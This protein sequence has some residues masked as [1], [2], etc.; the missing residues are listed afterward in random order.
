VSVTR[1]RDQS[2]FTLVELLVV[3]AIIGILVALLLPAIQAARE[4]ARS[5][6]CTNRMR[7]IAIGMQLYHDAN[8]AFPTGGSKKSNDGKGNKYNIG[9]AYL[10]MPYIEETNRRDQ[11]NL[12]HPNAFYMIEPWRLTNPPIGFGAQPVFTDPIATF[13]CPSSELGLLSPNAEPIADPQCNAENQGALHYR[14]NGGSATLEL[15]EGTFSRHA[16]YCTSGVIYPDSK[17][18]MKKITDGTSHTILLGETSSSIGRE[19]MNPY[20][21]GIQPWT[22]GYHYYGS[23]ERGWLMVDNKMVT[24]S[25]GYTGAFY[26]NETPFS[27][28]HGGGGAKIAFCD[29][30]IQYFSPETSLDI[31]Q[32]MATREGGEVLSTPQ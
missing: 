5:A 12:F 10:I 18:E 26:T 29:G 16:W 20:W 19:L 32:A 22:W 23:D 21:N 9:W 8:K 2:A 28:A 14:A 30:S 13:V 15:I 25:I 3:I 4:A 31:L 24:Y 7:Q 27:S 1:R 6:D 11:I 17:V